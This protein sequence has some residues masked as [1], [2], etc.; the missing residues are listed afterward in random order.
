MNQVTYK[1]TLRPVEA[2]YF[3]GEGSFTSKLPSGI[4]STDENAKKYFKPRQEYFAKSEMFPQ[5]TQLLGML[6]KELLRIEGKLF[7]F[8]NFVAIPHSDQ[9]EAKALIGDRRWSPEEKLSLGEIDAMGPLFLQHREKLY[10]GAP[11]DDELK[12]VAT[13]KGYINGRPTQAYA[14]EKRCDPDHYF[15]AKDYPCSDLVAKD[16]SRLKPDELFE[17]FVQTQTQTL[18]YKEDDE[19]QLFK[20]HKYRFKDKDTAFVFFVTMKKK[21]EM[22]NGLQTTVELGGERSAFTMSVEEAN[23]PD[24]QRDFV[25]LQTDQPRIVLLSDAKV[26]SSIF[27]CCKVTFSQK[28]IFRHIR[29]KK[30]FAKS[31]KIVM[32]AKGTVFYPKSNKIE[33]IK[34]KIDKATNFQTIG[35]N[36]YLDLT[37]GE[38]NEH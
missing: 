1:I 11:F 36:R 24:V 35:Y 6:R 15:G 8:K 5:Q 30:S 31:G 28:R 34:K 14:F 16:R 19:E 10:I 23:E 20:V 22:L 26:D 2:F 17:A 37:Q 21:I 3:G 33:E 25:F 13:G 7:Y 9:N 32:L 38:K 18:A 4:V 27:E 29:D 12:L